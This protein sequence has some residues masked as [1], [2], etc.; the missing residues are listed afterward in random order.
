MAYDSS[1]SN[2]IDFGAVEK[3]TVENKVKVQRIETF[4]GRGAHS[5]GNRSI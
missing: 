5:L 2:H 1:A 4:K 3:G